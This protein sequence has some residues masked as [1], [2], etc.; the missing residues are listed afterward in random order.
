MIIEGAAG[1]TVASFLKSKKRFKGKNV[2]LVLC[3]ANIG[4]EQLR[5]IICSI[6]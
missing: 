3:G 1:V 2:V 6:P 4:F 5:N